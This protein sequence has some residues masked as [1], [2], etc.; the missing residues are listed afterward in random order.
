MLLARH[1]A[2]WNVAAT[3]LGMTACMAPA[4]AAMVTTSLVMQGE[5]L[6]GAAPFLVVAGIAVGLAMASFAAPV[7]A[8]PIARAAP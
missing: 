4:L 1:R 8:D 5:P 6:V 3:A 2:A 7:T